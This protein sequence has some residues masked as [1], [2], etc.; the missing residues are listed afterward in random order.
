MFGFPIVKRRNKVDS[1]TNCTFAQINQRIQID[2][3]LYIIPTFKTHTLAR[4]LKAFEAF[5]TWQLQHATHVSGAAELAEAAAVAEAEG[6]P[7]PLKKQRRF[8]EDS[9][10]GAN[11][12][13]V[14]R[15]RERVGGGGAAVCLPLWRL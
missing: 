15:E 5:S 1:P 12:N 11:P 6:L 3:F 4:P 14:M 10:Q 13:E 2:I 9:M 8:R 7:I